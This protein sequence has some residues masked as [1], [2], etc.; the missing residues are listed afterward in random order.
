[1]N[2]RTRPPLPSLPLCL[3]LSI[4]SSAAAAAAEPFAG[5]VTEANAATR[6]VGGLGAVGGIGDYALGNG[7]L[8]AVV[9]NPAHGTDLSPHGGFLLDL[10]HCALGDDQLTSLVPLVNVDRANIPVV[11]QV[12]AAADDRE[13]R[14][15]TRARWQGLAFETDYVLDTVDPHSLRMETRVERVASG[16]RLA[17]VALLAVHPNAS[18]RA[19]TFDTGAPGAGVGF[20]HPA[21]PSENLRSL[22]GGLKRSDVQVLVG[23]EAG[24]AGIAYG[25]H[26]ESAW[27]VDEDGDRRALPHVALNGEPFTLLGVFSKPFRMGGSGRLGV[28]QLA[29]APLMNLPEGERLHLHHRI[30]VG[31]KADVAS[32]T[33][34]LFA[35]GPAVTGHVDD[36]DARLHVTRRGRPITHV[37]PEPDGRFAFHLP[38]PGSYEVRAVAPGGTEVRLP[39]EVAA[40]GMALGRVAL[41]GTGRVLLPRGYAMRLVFAGL[42]GTPDPRFGDDLI[43]LRFGG[44]EVPNSALAS[45]VSL[46]GS[47]DDP[48]SVALAP[49]RYRVLASRGLEWSVEETE[50]QVHGGRQTPLTIG[51]PRRQVETPGWILADLHVHA[52]GSFDSSLT[53]RERIRSFVA[54]GGEI[55]VATEH[56]NVVDYQPVVEAMG[57]AERLRV[58]PGLEVTTISKTEDVPYTAG[59][60]NAWPLPPQ[61]FAHRGG[62]FSSQGV[63][64]RAPIA[65]LRARGGRRIFQLNHPRMN[66]DESDDEALFTHLSVAGTG[67]VPSRALTESPNHHLAEPDPETGIRDLDYDAVELLNG[68]TGDDLAYYKRV[69]ADWFS[70]LLQGERHTATAN[71]DSHEMRQLVGIPANYVR[72]AADSVP[73]FAQGEFVAAVLAGA[74]VGSTGP[75]LSVDLLGAAAS[76]TPLV[77]PGGTFSGTGG[78][79]VV[80][81]EA[82]DWVPVD[83]LRVYLNG[84]LVES[85]AIARGETVRIPIAVSADAFVTVEVQGDP[86]GEA[87]ERYRAIAPRFVPFAFSNPIFIDADGDGAFTPP[88]LVPPLPATL[89][90][91]LGS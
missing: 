6:L 90:D 41:G 53:Y 63:R 73:A 8:C 22:L 47:E 37:R 3:A 13:A 58:V 72:V 31:A 34:R 14:V 4:V 87:G 86:A 44:E 74:L 9:S 52:G 18:L 24:G 16:G 2:R 32:V 78:E 33:D 12:E 1:M 25:L 85:R 15:T 79:L 59:H 5:P 46:A 69:R 70:L 75:F 7:T 11:E 35:E 49:G 39:L 76:R 54:Q 82:A 81:V 50:I 43:G 62:A 77:G 26:L 80:S 23:A 71:S 84:A 68:K 89:T 60:G 21:T 17:V 48:A 91:P 38:A 45:Y 30:H 65:E 88:G 28:L 42:D 20:D 83:A 27:R 36:P 19:F 57:L 40:E 51:I 64:L 29:Q 56:D 10:G 61:P 55:L 66:G 67:F